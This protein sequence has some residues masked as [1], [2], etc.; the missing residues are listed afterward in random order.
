MIFNS[1]ER[2]VAFR[3]LRARRTEGFVSIIALFSLLGI[4]LG[5][6]TLII[7]MSVMN[8]FRHDLLIRILGLDG[9]LSYY[10]NSGYVRN[11]DDLA[12]QIRGLPGIV[13]VA[14]V[15]EGQALI[16]SG[17]V[18]SGGIVHGIEPA[19][20]AHRDLISTH[21]V[22]GSLQNFSDDKIVIGARMAEKFD[23]GVGDKLTLVSPQ[24][25][26]G[27]F[28]TIPRTR[29][30]QIAAIFD[31]GMYEY[32][33]G[34]V[35]MPLA[36]AQLFYDMDGAATFLEI[37][38]PDPDRDVPAARREIHDTHPDAHMIDWQQAH[39]SYFNALKTERTVMF[40]I[41]TLIIVVAAFN[42]IS[43]MIMLV[44]DKTRDIAILR[45]IGATRG[46]ILRI[47]FLTGTSIGVFGTLLGFGIG[48]AFA[49]NIEAIRQ[50][51]QGL[52]HTNL[53]APEVYFLSQ[54]PAIV[55]W[56][57][58]ALIVGLALVLTFLATIIP[59]LRAARLD[60][61]EALRYE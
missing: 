33:S 12:Q 4:M 15:V 3:Y 23:V 38:V 48:V 24:G 54:L 32:D 21:I 41:L 53:F 39:A 42:I 20:F 8:G 59:A 51:L 6:A 35:F 11:Y 17:P 46:M 56:P 31:V 1:F 18:A 14:P 47:F 50:W 29:S 57:E 60:P 22:Q 30:Y 55:E 49:L 58:V 27:P 19:E 10:S 5:V 7:V 40:L 16:T 44:K 28:G 9:H 2:T 61:V 25:K 26:A 34:Y 52:T 13:S 43:S 37:M 45:T 36:A